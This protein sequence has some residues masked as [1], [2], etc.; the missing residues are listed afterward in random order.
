MSALPSISVHLVLIHHIAKARAHDSSQN[1][2]QI[3]YIILHKNSLIYLLPDINHR[4]QN[5]GQGNLP[6]PSHR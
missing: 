1:M 5:K 6:L 2:S 3:R 4:H